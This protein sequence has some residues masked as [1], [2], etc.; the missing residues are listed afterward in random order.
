MTSK[1]LFIASTIE[2]VNE[3]LNNLSEKYLNDPWV[4]L[5]LFGGLLIIGYWMI[6]SLNK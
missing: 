6:S 2:E 1:L 3:K 5:V 4:G